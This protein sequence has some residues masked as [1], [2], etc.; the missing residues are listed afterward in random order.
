MT[1]RERCNEIIRL[2]DEALGSDLVP[3]TVGRPE[4][5]T[6]PR[7]APAVRRLEA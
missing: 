5:R 6:S 2:I 3:G 7:P 4:S 1:G